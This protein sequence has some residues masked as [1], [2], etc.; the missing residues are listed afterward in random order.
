MRTRFKKSVIT[1]F[2]LCFVVTGITS[3]YAT[4]ML[5]RNAEELATLANRMFI[6]TCI[7]VEEKEMDFGG[8]SSLTYT[9]Y[10]FEVLEGIKGIQSGTILIIKQLGRATGLGSITGMPSY[11]SGRK[12]LLC[13]RD[14]SEVG[15][16]SP[17]GLGQGVFQIFTAQDGT[18]KAINLFSNKG[19]FHRMDSKP[20]AKYSTLDAEERSL[21][22]VKKGSIDLNLF[23]GLIKKMSK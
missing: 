14:D 18:E 2:T 6:G 16:T 12:Y 7:S 9:E 5:H 10:T 1:L 4:K 3:V 17:I 23:V 19:L 8:G 15:L 11:K 13:L 21:M 22:A 20:T